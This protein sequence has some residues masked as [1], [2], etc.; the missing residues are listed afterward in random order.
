[1]DSDRTSASLLAGR[2]ALV[3]GASRGIGRAVAV[4]LA[5]L[6]ARVVGVSRSTDGQAETMAEIAG[7]ERDRSNAGSFPLAAD[8]AEPGAVDA[9]FEE[10]DRRDVAVDIL[11]NN[12][13][14]TRDGLFVRMRDEDWDLV[15]TV[16]LKAPFLLARAAAR[17]MMRRRFGRIVNIGSVV[18][19][20]GNAGQ[21]NYAAAKAGLVGLTRSLAKELGGRGITANLVAPGFIE[22]DMTS[23]LAAERRRDL[24]SKVPLGRFGRPEDVA[25]AVAFLVGP[26]ASWITGQ[27]LVVDGGM[28][29]G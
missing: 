13:G 16:D 17:G 5:R 29:L 15:Q 6:G 12:A 3:T 11:V 1:M 10:L 4:E 8:L 28:S 27:V 14:L 24:L 25:G 23:T 2:T 7:L 21:A 20:T 26:S 18:G 9:L 19:L 22:T